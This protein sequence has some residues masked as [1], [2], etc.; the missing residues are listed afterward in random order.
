MCRSLKFLV[1]KLIKARRLKRYIIEIDH[2]V[3]SSKVVDIIT[4]DTVAQ[5]ES[6]LAINY[7]LG[8]PS[9]DQYQSK[10]Q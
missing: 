10:R 3:E 2:G 7:I 9:N 8:G 6:R 4:V 5:S 1:E